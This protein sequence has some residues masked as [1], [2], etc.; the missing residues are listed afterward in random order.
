MPTQQE[1]QA[2]IEYASK[3]GPHKLREWVDQMH[4]EIRAD[5]EA[6][7]VPPAVLDYMDARRRLRILTSQV[8]RNIFQVEHLPD[9]ALPIYDKDPE[10][11]QIVIQD[12]E[13]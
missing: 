13:D 11:A 2:V 1:I 9:G 12:D 6:K 4:A 8:A 3:G 5:L 10:V 7:G